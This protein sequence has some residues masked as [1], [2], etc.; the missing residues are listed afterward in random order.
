MPWSRAYLT[1]F[2]AICEEWPSTIR[3]LGAESPISL[4]FSALIS[5]RG[6]R[7]SKCYLIYSSPSSSSIYPLSDTAYVAFGIVANDF[8]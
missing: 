2:H 1:T 7:G 8:E 3:H 6:V 5:L 4:A